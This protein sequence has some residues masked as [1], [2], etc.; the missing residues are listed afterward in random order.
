M[1]ISGTRRTAKQFDEHIGKKILELR[2]AAGI[3]RDT[4]SQSLGVSFQQIQKFEAGV[5]RISAGQLWLLSKY[6]DVPIASMFEGVSS[7]MFKIK[8]RRKSR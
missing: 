8:P 1:G 2:T 6:F 7:T 3:S 5:N 4:L